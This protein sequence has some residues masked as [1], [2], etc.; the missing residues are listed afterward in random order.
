M[1][2]LLTRLNW[3]LTQTSVR[4]IPTVAGAHDVPLLSGKLRDSLKLTHRTD[5]TSPGPSSTDYTSQDPLL[6]AFWLVW[7]IGM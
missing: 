7:P 2:R 4:K 1:I 3:L 6:A 5:T